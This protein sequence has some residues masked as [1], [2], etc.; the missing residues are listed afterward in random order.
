M[1]PAAFN[2]ERPETVSAAIKLLQDTGGSAKIL[3]GGQSLGPMLNMRLINPTLLIDIAR[4]SELNDISDD[5][6]ALIFGACVTHAAIEDRMVPDASGGMMPAVARGIA[7][8]AVRNKGTI[9]GSLA[10]A[11]P[12]ADWPTVLTALD[13]K[14]TI[15][16]AGGATRT[17]EPGDFFVGPLTT[18][19]GEHEMLT[20]IEV[21]TLGCLLYTSDAADE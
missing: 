13:A 5:G 2:Y 16:S 4:I 9:G 1:K 8:R 12:A 3:A 18:T 15:Q 17:V 21:P 6:D 20:S 14:F 10:H 11:D 19:L 7:Y